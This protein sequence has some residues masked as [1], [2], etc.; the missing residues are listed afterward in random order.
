MGME[1][2]VDLDWLPDFMTD[3][4]I[5]TAHMTLGIISTAYPPVTTT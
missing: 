4:F 2:E 3:I 1:V 5:H